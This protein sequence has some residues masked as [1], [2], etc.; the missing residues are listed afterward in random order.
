M[1]TEVLFW[2][3]G[4]TPRRGEQVSDGDGNVLVS[5]DW[6]ADPSKVSRLSPKEISE[7]FPEPK[8]PANDNG[9]NGNNGKTAPTAAVVA[10]EFAAS[11][12]R[13][14]AKSMSLPTVGGEVAVAQRLLDAGWTPDSGKKSN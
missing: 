6:P 11:E 7:L 14:I 5:A 1:K 13:S 10:K 2:H 8:S 9:N 4:S 12:L 3:D